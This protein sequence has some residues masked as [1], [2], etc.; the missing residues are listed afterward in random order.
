MLVDGVDVA[1]MNVRWLRAQIG[2]DNQ[3][4]PLLADTVMNNIRFGNVNASDAQV[5]AAAEAAACTGFIDALP[6]KFETRVGSG[7]IQLSG[8]QKQVWA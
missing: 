4:P 2:L 7:G 3:E 6:E 5:A 8:G 1:R